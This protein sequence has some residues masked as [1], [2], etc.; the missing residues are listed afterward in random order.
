MRATF[1]KAMRADLLCPYSH[2]PQASF[3]AIRVGGARVLLH[4]HSTKGEPI[5]VAH[6]WNFEL[7]AGARTL[8]DG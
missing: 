7:A 4:P 5:A 2:A 3:V 6:A 8:M 1:G